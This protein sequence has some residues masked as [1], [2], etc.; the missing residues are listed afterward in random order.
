MDLPHSKLYIPRS[1]GACEEVE[2]DYLPLRYTGV[3][4]V[5]HFPHRS[6]RRP[7][8]HI[9]PLISTSGLP[10]EYEV[11]SERPKLLVDVSRSMQVRRLDPLRTSPDNIVQSLRYHLSKCKNLPLIL[12][13]RGC[14]FRVRRKIPSTSGGGNRGGSCRVSLLEGL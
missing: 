8:I 1:S 7:P 4:V 11:A 5:S 13:I 14:L 2:S 9:D 10:R 3:S 6:T 12:Q